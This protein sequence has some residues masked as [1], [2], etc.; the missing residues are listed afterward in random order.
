MNNIIKLTDK[1]TE[2]VAKIIIDNDSTE[3]NNALV[4]G[5][6]FGLEVKWYS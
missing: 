3:I 5:C 4:V 6:G 2:K 1:K